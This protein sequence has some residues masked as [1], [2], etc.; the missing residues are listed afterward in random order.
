MTEE[1][2]EHLEKILASGLSAADPGE[3]VRRLL[4]V[5]GGEVRVE[6]QSFSAKRVFVFAAGKAAGPMASAAVEALGGLVSGG[7]VVA[8]DGNDMPGAVRE[9]GLETFFAAHPEP[10]ERGVQAARRVSERAEYLGEGDL[11]LCLVSGGASA[12]LADP[13]PS[14]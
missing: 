2:K 13:H 4:Y 1:R 12:L 9:A 14:V 5:E 10:D 6:E 7:I 11:L 8:K 3:A